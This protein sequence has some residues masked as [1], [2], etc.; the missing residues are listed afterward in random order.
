MVV[1]EVTDPPFDPDSLKVETIPIPDHLA[2]DDAPPPSLDDPVSPPPRQRKRF[3]GKPTP[4]AGSRDMG[5]RKIRK[6]LPPIPR[7][8]FAPSVEKMYGNLAV[9][10]M[11]FDME[12]A[13]AIVQ[14]APDAAKAWDELARQNEVVRRVLVSMMQTTAVGAVIAAH[15]PIMVLVMGR[16]MNGDPRISMIGQMLANEAEK[17]ANE[18]KPTE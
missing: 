5:P 11:P 13:S 14:V 16:V 1:R 15:V 10:V 18:E 7:S 2:S 3:L 4:D 17:H 8:G 12:L 6:P 9:A